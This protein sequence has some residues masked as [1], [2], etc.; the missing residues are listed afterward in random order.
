[1]AGGPHTVGGCPQCQRGTGH[2]LPSRACFARSARVA[3]AG[4]PTHEIASSERDLADEGGSP[5]G[6]TV[7]VLA[8]QVRALDAQ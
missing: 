3:L 1:M 4:A 5:S 2:E 6:R 8:H 7:D